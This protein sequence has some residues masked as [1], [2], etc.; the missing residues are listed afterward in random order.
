MSEAAKLT[1][2]AIE[3]MVAC[4]RCKQAQG[5]PC[6]TK[7]KRKLDVPHMARIREAYAIPGLRTEQEEQ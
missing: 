2:R 4:P 7:T 3:E 6:V 1:F 5:Q